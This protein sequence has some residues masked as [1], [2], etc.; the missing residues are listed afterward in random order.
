MSHHKASQRDLAKEHQREYLP[1][2]T[3][4]T[5]ILL[6]GAMSHHKASQ[7]QRLSI[8]HGI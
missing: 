1:V 6:L 7:N 3:P 8:K 2:T 4:Y 5:H